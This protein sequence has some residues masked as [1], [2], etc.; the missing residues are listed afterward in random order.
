MALGHMQEMDLVSPQSWN[1]NKPF[2]RVNMSQKSLKSSKFCP[3]LQPQHVDD[4]VLE[5][6]GK[7]KL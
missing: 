3:T 6:E 2:T 5:V 4:P 7:Y 1:S